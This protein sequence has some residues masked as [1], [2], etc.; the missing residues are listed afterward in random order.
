MTP[1]KKKNTKKQSILEDP[2]E[3]GPPIVDTNL[4][5]EQ[6]DDDDVEEQITIILKDPI[7]TEDLTCEYCERILS[8]IQ[9][10]TS[11]MKTQHGMKVI[12][13][14][15]PRKG[16]AKKAE[17]KARKD[18]KEKQK[19][20]P[21]SILDIKNLIPQGV[22]KRERARLLFQHIKES[23]QVPLSA[24]VIAGL[25]KRESDIFET[26][27]IG[28]GSNSIINDD[29]RTESTPEVCQP[30]LEPQSK[31]KD[32]RTRLLMIGEE[33]LTAIQ[34]ESVEMSMDEPIHPKKSKKSVSEETFGHYLEFDSKS[35]VA[36][37]RAKGFH[38][39]VC[40]AFEKARISGY[41]IPELVN[42]DFLKSLGITT[43][44]DL[45]GLS[46]MFQMILDTEKIGN[47]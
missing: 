6:D 13:E 5:I 25:E 12:K 23:K 35:I 28:L 39:D 7:T 11:H 47:E 18:L 30:T 40:E 29:E 31:K 20:I 24:Q 10:F 38:E 37:V 32:K 33:K 17:M 42:K 3:D 22:E 36:Y 34:N 2:E 16:D 46:H 1:R 19:E 21:R 14:K 15:K 44:G 27:S 45:G 8:S 9:A 41:N 26:E 4:S 43:L